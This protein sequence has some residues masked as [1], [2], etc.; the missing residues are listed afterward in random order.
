[1]H[2]HLNA[3]VHIFTAM[4][5]TMFSIASANQSILPP[6][7]P[8]VIVSR[9]H[10]LNTHIYRNISFLAR[11]VLGKFVTP[12][13][14]LSHNYLLYQS[15]NLPLHTTYTSYHGIKTRSPTALEAAPSARHP[16]DCSKPDQTTILLNLRN[17]L[18]SA[19]PPHRTSPNQRQW[20][21]QRDNAR[22]RCVLHPLRNAYPR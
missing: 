9:P 7:T 6:N 2:A 10:C 8:H 17:R 12:Q 15:H 1:M 14:H 3:S 19:P 11:A 5:R 18:Q 22:S 16:Q 20:P 21:V 13:S 4:C